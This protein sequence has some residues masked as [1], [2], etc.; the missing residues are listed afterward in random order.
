MDLYYMDRFL[1]WTVSKV[2]IIIKVSM[3]G[4]NCFNISLIQHLINASK[5]MFLIELALLL[6]NFIYLLLK[7][8]EVFAHWI[9]LKSES[10]L[11]DPVF[12]HNLGLFEFVFFAFSIK[13][14]VIKERL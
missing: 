4:S 9:I 10:L 12:K 5:Q 13:N 6:S 3:S 2:K 1:L 8:I 7:L 14:E 11:F